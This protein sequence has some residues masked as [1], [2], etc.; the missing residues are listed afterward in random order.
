MA[1]SDPLNIPLVGEAQNNKYITVNDAIQALASAT[2]KILAKDTIGTGPV[3]LT[4]NESSRNM[5]YTLAG[6]SAAFDM[7][8]RSTIGGL[9][10]QRVMLVVNN[11]S[12]PATVKASSGSGASVIVYPGFSALLYQ[13]FEDIY[14][15]SG[16]QLAGEVMPYDLSVYIPEQPGDAAEIMRVKM[17]RSVFFADNF[18]GSQASVFSNPAS[19]AAFTVQKNGSP[20]GSITIGTGGGATFATTG[21]GLETFAPGDI[22]TI[23]A[24]T[25]QDVSLAGVGITLYGFQ[26]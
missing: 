21:S 18:T 25:P 13:S 7:T 26:G 3:A 8:F 22:L 14:R 24:P 20:I 10:A 12:Y 4:E 23:L 1:N 9:N 16:N 17:T 15:L 6:A 2:N 5:V 11:T 19:D